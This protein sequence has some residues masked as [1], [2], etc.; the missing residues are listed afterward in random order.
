ML[1]LALAGSTKIAAATPDLLAG[2]G[3]TQ[4]GGDPTDTMVYWGIGWT[5]PSGTAS[6][7]YDPTTASSNNIAGS[8][9]VTLDCQGGPE[10]IVAGQSVNSANIALFYSL[11]PGY[12]AGWLGGGGYGYFDMSKYASVSF[13][14]MVNTLV[15]SNTDIPITLWAQYSVVQLIPGNGQNPDLNAAENGWGVGAT[16]AGW[17]HVV[18]PFNAATAVPGVNGFGAYL[19]YQTGASTPSS[20][21]E[22]WLDNIRFE[23]AVAPPPPPTVTLAPLKQFGLMLDS[24]LGDGAKPG[25]NRQG[26]DTVASYPWEA[27]ASAG[28]PV[29][30]S[31]TITSAPNPAI[32]SNYEAH[33]FLAPQ[34]GLGNPDNN[35]TDVGWLRIVDSSDGTATATMMWKTNSIFDY[36]MF[37]NTQFGGQYGTNGLAAGDLG[38]LK[39]PTMLGTWSIAFTSDTA[40]TVSG[41]G[42]ISTNFSFPSDW[43]V[44]FDTSGANNGS[45]YAYFGADCVSGANQG[46]LVL[47]GVSVSGGGAAYALTNNFSTNLDSTVWGTIGTE[48]HVVTPSTPWLVSWTLPAAN[49]DLVATAYLTNPIPWVD[50]SANNTNLPVP[51]ATYQSGTNMKALVATADLP[52]TNITFFALRQVVATQLQVLMPGETSAPG[53]ATGKTGTPDPQA[54]GSLCNVTVHAVDAHWNIAY[55][56]ADTVHL[57]SSD[58]FAYLGNDAA[59]VN[60]AVTFS[61]QFF[62]AGQQTIT[63]SDVTKTTVTAN[64]G[65]STTVTP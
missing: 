13:D 41:P 16:N 34:A 23:A 32:Y 59:L 3:A 55:G 20:H 54:A 2:P 30:Y 24:G 17:H 65:S 38:T 7:I 45:V 60:G 31:M 1:C 56:C 44:S 51:L 64:T 19:W 42:G 15:S 50:L 48:T 63:A 22:Y 25:Q 6:I 46:A 5:D 29:T 52:S 36:T 47:S 28:S 49:F 62:T 21:L 57:T 33:I 18:I 61:V 12:Y 40:F 11:T 35:C 10:Q 37:Y 53:T 27:N 4:P 9:Y 58:A 43:L 26:L 14:I 39:A 8:L